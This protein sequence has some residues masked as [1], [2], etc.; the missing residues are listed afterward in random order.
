MLPD[1]F[2]NSTLPVLDQ[3]VQ[4]A[5][6]RHGL[7]AGNIAN[8]DT[9]GYKTRDLSTEAFESSLREA[10]ESTRPRRSPGDGIVLGELGDEA[11]VFGEEGLVAPREKQP[12]ARKL[13]TEA[14]QGVRDSIKHVL[15]HDG[16]D[17]SLENQ[18]TQIS[19]NQAMHNLAITLM[20][21][22]FR[23]LRSAISETVT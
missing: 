9:P 10:I 3:V 21:S 7:L 14:L 5:Q 12:L 19:K 16:S 18:V 6:A 1:L 11:A 17:V 4:F 2:S 23:L 20:S 13:D 8:L 22:Q 15:F